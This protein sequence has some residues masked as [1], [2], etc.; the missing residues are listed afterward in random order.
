MAAP[1][2][3]LTVSPTTAV[4]PAT[5]TL[6][7]TST[8]IPA[9]A[10]CTASGAYGWNGTK[11]PN[12][13]F[14]INGVKQ[15]NTYTLTCVTSS[16]EEIATWTPPTKNTDGSSIPSTGPGSLASY[17]VATATS[18]DA[19]KTVERV[20]VPAS[21]LTYTFK[22]IP[23]GE[24]FFAVR[25]V[26]IEGIK[27]DDVTVSSM[28]VVPSVT[29]NASVTI[30]VKPQPPIVTLSTNAYNLS[31]SGALGALVGNIPLNSECIGEPKI[32]RW[33]GVTFY[34]VPHELVTFNKPH[35]ALVVVKC[36]PPSI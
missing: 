12:G 24:N 31:N 2:L 10:I 13:T 25:A 26:N 7:W 30:N 27:S 15:S 1:T 4:S 16:G 18:V 28:M 36:G 6:S 3:T 11:P 19:L 33:T 23:V 22:N 35:K 29:A 21:V 8:E 34:E 5:I 20:S 17:E 9:D 14:T 32:T